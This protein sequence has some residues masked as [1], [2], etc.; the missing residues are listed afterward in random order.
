MKSR[1]PIIA[2]CL[3]FALPLQ[4]ALSVSF[5]GSVVHITGATP[6]GQVALVAVMREAHGKMITRLNDTQQLLSDPE[7]DGSID[8]DLKRAVPPR[9]IWVVVDVAS[10]ESLITAPGDFPKRESALP[11][12]FVKNVPADEFDTLI[13]ENLL[14]HVLWVRTGNGNGNGSAGAWFMRAADG[15]ANDTDHKTNGRA[16]LSTA[17]FVPLGDSGQAPKK[18]KKGDVIVLLDPFAMT[19]A[20]GV[21]A[22]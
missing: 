5:E 1:F 2:V 11:P 3:F 10:G 9:S 13:G 8:Y 12:G 4:A 21:I 7:G 18:L 16:M 19:S 17:G 15:G 6:R 20:R 14:L 22:Q